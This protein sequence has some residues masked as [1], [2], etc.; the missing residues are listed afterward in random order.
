MMFL[1]IPTLLKYLATPAGVF[2]LK[3]AGV[4]LF[5]AVLFIT[6]A[7]HQA[8][9]DDVKSLEA[10]NAALRLANEVAQRDLSAARDAE[11]TANQQSAALNAQAS[12]LAG[13][14]AEIN[15][16]SNA[17]GKGAPAN[18]PCLVG[19]YVGRLRGIK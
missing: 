18:G 16:A 19:P 17:Q 4:L 13:K 10:R 14:L 12:D 3:V 7:N 8:R 9:I 6:G 15:A 2:L 11:A 5:C 1:W